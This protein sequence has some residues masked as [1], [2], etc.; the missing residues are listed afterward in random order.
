MSRL[1]AIDKYNR[2][3]ISRLF[4]V[5]IVLYSVCLLLILN[6]V[7][8]V[9]LNAVVI[10]AYLTFYFFLSKKD[11]LLSIVRLINDYVFI[12]FICFSVDQESFLTYALIIAPILNTH[13][14]SGD[15]PSILLY[16]I[17]VS[18]MWIYDN[19]VEWLYLI[20][21]GMF[22]IINWFDTL[23]MRY[24]RLHAKLNAVIDSF[25][26]NY[27]QDDM[28]LL[29]RKVIRVFN[30]EKIF[31]NTSEIICLI[32]KGRTLFVRNGSSYHVK[33]A[34]NNMEEFIEMRDQAIKEGALYGQRSI[35]YIIDGQ[36]VKNSTTVF[37]EVNDV[38]FCYLIIKTD[39]SKRK[40]SVRSYLVTIIT[41][42][43][44]ERI[45]VAMDSNWNKKKE[46][47]REI[48]ALSRKVNHVNRSVNAMHFIR[49]KIQPFKT[50][51]DILEDY[52]TE[53]DQEKKE[54]KK[55]HL[56]SESKKLRNSFDE[57][58]GQA[59]RILDNE[60]NPYPVSE[61]KGFRISDFYWQ[62]QRACDYFFED[63][64]VNL[65]GPFISPKE[66]SYNELGLDLILTNWLANMRKYSTGE[67]R[68]Q[69]LNGG[70]K[71]LLIFRNAFDPEKTSSGFGK[72][73]RDANR[74]AITNRKSHGLSEIRSFLEQMDVHS[75]LD[76]VDNKVEFILE[77]K[78]IEKDENIGH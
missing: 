2:K 23:R 3:T 4:R 36:D 44:F 55:V 29:Y 65:V 54:L 77:F 26:A 13:N 42:P 33:V 46:Q 30:G 41:S 31:S 21:M 11:G 39:Q 53:N 49:N 6:S 70:D 20:P 12:G 71:Y 66:L 24:I 1:L 45:S 17:P 76:V 69:I 73:Y 19:K 37:T 32:N 64:T 57:I 56:K 28:P 74:E 51:L 34:P 8:D 38:V 18:L 35:D 27:Q 67:N 7:Y 61:L 72:L 52:E 50:Y 40:W 15:K 22:Y 25:L 5:V 78:K 58:V 9:F 16:L 47:M 62:V 14:H 75:S 48:E 63:I 10:L 59:N 68:I 60:N 43:L